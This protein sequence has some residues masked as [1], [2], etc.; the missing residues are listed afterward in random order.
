MNPNRYRDLTVNQATVGSNPTMR[1]T[2]KLI[3]Y[4][5]ALSLQIEEELD[6]FFKTAK[7]GDFY[8]I[9]YHDNPGSFTQLKDFCFY[10]RS[11][12]E[13]P[14]IVRN[15]KTDNDNYIIE[16]KSYTYMNKHYYRGFYDGYVG[17]GNGTPLSDHVKLMLEKEEEMA[18]AVSKISDKLK[19]VNESFTVNMY[20][21]GYMIEVGGKD[22]KD[23]WKTA[24]IT[25]AELDSLIALIKEVVAMER[26]N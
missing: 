14:C 1:A 13:I 9:D 20:D 24:K 10:Q 7:T 8:E 6:N 2:H 26:D 18:K 12:N 19:V 3:G 22:S 5:M 17:G 15:R 23:D 16:L 4:T 25:V 21:N 11:Q